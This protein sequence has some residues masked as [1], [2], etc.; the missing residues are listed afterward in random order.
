[1]L[2]IFAHLFL[3]INPATIK[4]AKEV[5]EAAEGELT[6]SGKELHTANQITKLLLGLSLDEQNPIEGIKFQIGNFTG[7]LKK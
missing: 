6:S 1:M 3:D 5:I 7:R 2:K 4:N